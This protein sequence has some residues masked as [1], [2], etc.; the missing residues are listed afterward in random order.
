MLFANVLVNGFPKTIFALPTVMSAIS[1][2]FGVAV[3]VTLVGFDAVD[4]VWFKN[5][6]LAASA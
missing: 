3:I 4:T 6:N 1:S 2:K 5:S